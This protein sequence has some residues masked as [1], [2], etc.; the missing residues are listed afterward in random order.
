VILDAELVREN[1]QSRFSG[2]VP[3]KPS[4]GT[5]ATKRRA[6]VALAS[7]AATNSATRLLRTIASARSRVS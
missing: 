3:T 5:V 1:V 2:P 7:P 4:V 6:S